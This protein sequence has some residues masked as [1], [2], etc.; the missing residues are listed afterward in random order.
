MENANEDFKF[1]VGKRIME[2]RIKAGLTREMLAEIAGISTKYVY[3]IEMGKK[4]VSLYIIHQV[5]RGL[6][7]NMGYIL[8]EERIDKCDSLDEICNKFNK[9][10]KKQIIQI[11]EIIHEII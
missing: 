4:N 7:I 10:Q 11:I 5:C 9:K 2:T 1:I 3:D 8:S 6:D